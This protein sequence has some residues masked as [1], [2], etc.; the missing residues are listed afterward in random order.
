MSEEQEEERVEEKSRREVIAE[1]LE[2]AGEDIQEDEDVE[3]SS[4]DGEEGEEVS[5]DTEEQDSPAM[6]AKQ[7]EE[8]AQP[9][10]QGVL[11]PNDLNEEEKKEFEELAKKAPKTAAKLAKRFYDYRRDYTQKTERAAETERRATPYLQEAAKHE[12]RLARKQLSPQQV[13]AN[14]LAWDH[15]I[16]EQGV[17]ALVQFVE[18][19]GFDVQELAEAV[20]SGQ[21]FTKSSE[22]AQIP[23]HI[24]EKIDRLERFEQQ[25]TQA[26]QSQQVEQTFSALNQF[27]ASKPLFKDPATAEQLEAAMAPLVRGFRASNPSTPPLELLEKAYNYVVNGDERF[28]P[29]LDGVEKKKTIEAERDRS[30]R[31]LAA[32]SVRGSGP[33]SGTPSSVPKGRRAQIAAALDGRLT[34]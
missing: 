13:F 10:I 22:E 9:N 25:Y 15:F 8:E 7:V 14:A 2:A 18:S 21:A 34:I 20:E 17:N 6:D 19:H 28:R 12:Q 3:V 16:D 4:F 30:S 29:L 1:A 24:Q 11:P 26:Q 5:N 33:G 23:R 27:K 31:A 32:S